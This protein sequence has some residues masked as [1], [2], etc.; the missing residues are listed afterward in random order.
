MFTSHDDDNIDAAWHGMTSSRY[1]WTSLVFCWIPR[2]PREHFLYW[3]PI[4][5][6]FVRGEEGIV[7][8]IYEIAHENLWF[9]DGISNVHKFDKE[10]L[11]VCHR[12]MLVAIRHRPHHYH[13]RYDLRFRLLNSSRE[14]V[15]R[16]LAEWLHFAGRR[17]WYAAIQRLYKIRKLLRLHQ[18]LQRTLK[19]L[20]YCW[21]TMHRNRYMSQEQLRRPTPVLLL[22]GAALFQK[23][24]CGHAKKRL[25]HM[26]R[27]LKIVKNY[28]PELMAG[29]VEQRAGYLDRGDP[30]RDELAFQSWQNEGT[31]AAG[32]SLIEP[33]VTSSTLGALNFGCGAVA[34]FLSAL[35]KC[36]DVNYLL[37]IIYYVMSMC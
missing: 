27:M 4:R 37:F 20:P 1:V 12:Q 8:I 23:S 19:E 14:K 6:T 26:L 3:K 10:L 30:N 16:Y 17:G 34:T 15:R 18:E 11:W 33:R 9:D 29:A 13:H 2:Y 31:V 25:W 32:I 35:L 21:Q 7:T 28:S 22:R 5:W 24:S 36:E